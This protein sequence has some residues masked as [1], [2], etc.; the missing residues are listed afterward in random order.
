M[1]KTMDR[2]ERLQVGRAHKSSTHVLYVIR[3]MNLLFDFDN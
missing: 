1:I 3:G 2:G